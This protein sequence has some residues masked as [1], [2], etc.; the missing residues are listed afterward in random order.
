MRDVEEFRVALGRIPLERH[1]LQTERPLVLRRDSREPDVR[2][3]SVFCEAGFRAPD[4]GRL[5]RALELEG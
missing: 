1:L 3:A 4:L 5:K 2:A